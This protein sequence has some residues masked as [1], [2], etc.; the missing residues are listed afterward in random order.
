MT[1]KLYAS[2]TTMEPIYLSE[3]GTTMLFHNHEEGKWFYWKNGFIINYNIYR[4]KLA[5]EYNITLME[6]A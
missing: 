5:E 6:K 4:S 3:D 2:N 1:L